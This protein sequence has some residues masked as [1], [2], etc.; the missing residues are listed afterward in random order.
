MNSE[1]CDW[2]ILWNEIFVPKIVKFVYF[3]HHLLSCNDFQMTINSSFC[4]L[5]FYRTGH[6]QTWTINVYLWNYLF[7]MMIY[8]MRNSTSRIDKQIDWWLW[9]WV[10]KF[11][12]LKTYTSV[13]VSVTVL[14][15]DSFFLET[16]SF[17]IYYTKCLPAKGQNKYQIWNWSNERRVTSD[18]H[19]TMLIIRWK[20]YQ[21]VWSCLQTCANTS[22]VGRWLR[23][24]WSM[25]N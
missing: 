4:C 18:S 14:S 10:V 6:T 22:R 7:M 16:V 12:R 2:Q 20:C 8:G 19:S 13:C 17:H 5:M 3:Q 23:K 25:R 9:I 21:T 24:N 11:Y 15:I 1:Y